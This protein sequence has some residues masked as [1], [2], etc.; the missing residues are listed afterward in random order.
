MQVYVA[1][2]F[3]YGVSALN[4]TEEKAPCPLGY[5]PCGNLTMCL[6]Q[7]MHCN[8]IDDCGNQADEENCDC[9]RSSSSSAGDG[10]GDCRQVSGSSSRGSHLFPSVETSDTWLL[11]G[12][13][14]DTWI[15]LIYVLPKTHTRLIQSLNSRCVPFFVPVLSFN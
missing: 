13:G 3:A 11:E 10:T 4:V 1:V 15:G 14:G 12:M 7:P 6:P 8:G 5:F 2:I 9:E